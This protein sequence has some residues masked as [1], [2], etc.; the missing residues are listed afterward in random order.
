MLHRMEGLLQIA[1]L[2]L[3]A[4]LWIAGAAVAS[5]IVV[6]AMNRRRVRL[7]QL[8]RDHVERVQ[9][10]PDDGTGQENAEEPESTVG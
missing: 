4:W 3:S 7:T 9:T 5:W 8:L 10:P 2:S 6:D 1:A